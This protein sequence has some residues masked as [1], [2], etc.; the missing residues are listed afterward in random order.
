MTTQ[1]CARPCMCRS[2]CADKH[3]IELQAGKIPTD[4]K[5][6]HSEE[7]AIE[8]SGKHL[9]NLFPNENYTELSSIDSWSILAGD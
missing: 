2:I 7:Q 5:Y 1:S 8:C 4:C 9:Q 3:S 6:L